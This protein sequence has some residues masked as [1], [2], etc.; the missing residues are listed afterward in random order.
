MFTS[1]KKIWHNLNRHHP[2]K[3]GHISKLNTIPIGMSPQVSII[4]SNKNDANKLMNAILETRCSNKP[5]PFT[6][7]NETQEKIDLLFKEY[8][9]YEPEKYQ[10]YLSNKNRNQITIEKL[11]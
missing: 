3:G 2:A 11:L 4:L 1:L 5:A 10:Q 9:K 7:S 8:H 6:I